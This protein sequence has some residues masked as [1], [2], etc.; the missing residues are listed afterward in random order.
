[1]KTTMDA[2]N[3]LRGDLNNSNL[4]VWN[5]VNLI[6]SDGKYYT[7]VSLLKEFASD[8]VCPIEEFNEIKG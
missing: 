6:F 5:G 3:D 8:F 7:T 1:M 2:I 4:L